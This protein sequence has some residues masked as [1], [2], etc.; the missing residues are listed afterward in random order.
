MK[1]NQVVTNKLREP[2]VIANF[3]YTTPIVERWKVNVQLAIDAS[4]MSFRQFHRLLTSNGIKMDRA[5]WYRKEV[6]KYPN[7]LYLG[8][9]SRL[10][11]IE[12]EYLL[13]KDFP[14]MLESG[15]IKPQ[16]LAA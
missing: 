10:L 6:K 13:S 4:G 12:P 5:L 7:F 16:I 2:E 14:Q 8:T 9:F 3:N 11:G 15:K 1:Q